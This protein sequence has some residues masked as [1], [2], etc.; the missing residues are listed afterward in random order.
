MKKPTLYFYEN[1][2]F[3]YLYSELSRR[4][5]FDEC[6]ITPAFTTQVKPLKEKAGFVN[7]F[8]EKTDEWSLVEDHRGEKVYSKEDGSETEITEVGAIPNTLTDKKCPGQ[9]YHWSDSGWAFNIEEQAAETV[10]QNTDKQ[11]SLSA[12]AEEKILILERKIKAKRA[13]DTEKQLLVALCDFTID[14]DKLDLTK[15]NIVWPPV[16]E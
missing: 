15:E 13:T 11:H 9:F 14:L 6:W 12:T 2:T 1:N 4:D 16:P 8:N 3:I 5:P 10:R 7:V